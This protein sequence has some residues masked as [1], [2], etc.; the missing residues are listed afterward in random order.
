MYEISTGSNPTYNN[1]V[2]SCEPCSLDQLTITYSP[3]LQPHPAIYIIHQA[4]DGEVM[5]SMVGVPPSL[6]KSESRHLAQVTIMDAYDTNNRYLSN[7]ML[8]TSLAWRSTVQTPYQLL[9][10][11]LLA[12]CLIQK[13]HKIFTTNLIQ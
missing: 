8:A 3:T 9:V 4:R 6:H 10:S 1:K 13:E 2:R 11:C 7:H 5:A 12:E